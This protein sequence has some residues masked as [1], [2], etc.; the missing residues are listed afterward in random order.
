M[1]VMVIGT[2]AGNL[3]V[4]IVALATGRYAAAAAFAAIAI[5]LFLYGRT[6]LR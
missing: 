1:A 2:A 3:V 4:A 5:A 6:L